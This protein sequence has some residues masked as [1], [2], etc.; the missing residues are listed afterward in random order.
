MKTFGSSNSS[1]TDVCIIAAG[2]AAIIIAISVI[3][4]VITAGPAVAQFAAP[5]AVPPAVPPPAVP[6]PAVTPV[7]VPALMAPAVAAPGLA[8][9]AVAAPA[10]NPVIAAAAGDATF[11]LG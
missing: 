3:F 10:V 1:D 4:P 5:S 2:A 9:P 7:V 6:P 8:A 11:T